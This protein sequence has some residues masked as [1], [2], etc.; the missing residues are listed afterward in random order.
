MPGTVSDI[1]DAVILE[2]SQVPGVSTQI[3]AEPRLLQLVEDAFDLVFQENWWNAY[4]SYVT[5]TLNGTTGLLTAD[6][7]PTTP[8]AIVPISSYT[9][10][11]TCFMS[12]RR[13]PIREFPPM[14]NPNSI[15]GSLPL[16]KMPDYTFPNRPIKFLPVDATGDV[17]MEVRQEPLHP[18]ALTD[19]IYIDTKMLVWGAAFLY[20]SDDGTNPGQVAKFQQLFENRLKRMKAAEG[21]IKL[22][23]DDRFPDSGFDD[24]YMELN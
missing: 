2:I 21:D 8:S 20:V 7:L 18:F 16:Y 23:T 10:I 3:Y 9:N 1:V 5:G 4:S 22:S 11:R 17:I 6:I 12:T 24:Q 13:R 15:S 19:T 14:T